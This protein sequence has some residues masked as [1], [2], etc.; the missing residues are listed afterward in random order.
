MLNG[1]AGQR[2]PQAHAA[3]S[4]F[5]KPVIDAEAATGAEDAPAI[6]HKRFG[7][8]PLAAV[9]FGRDG[10]ALA[11]SRILIARIPGN[12]RAAQIQSGHLHSQGDR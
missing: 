3:V 9:V 5:L 10:E 8:D 1:L 7:F 4:I 6:R 2:I 12:A 11:K